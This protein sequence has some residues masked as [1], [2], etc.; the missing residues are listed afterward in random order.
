MEHSDVL[1]LMTRLKLFGMRAAY[2]EVMAMATAGAHH[3]RTARR[4]DRREKGALDQVSADHR[5]I[6]ARHGPRR[7]HLCRHADQP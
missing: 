7:L 3:R 1:E 4:R 6:A 5:Q 2:D